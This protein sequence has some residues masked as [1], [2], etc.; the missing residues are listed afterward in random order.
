MS[1][2]GWFEVICL[3]IR[4][5]LIGMEVFLEYAKSRRRRRQRSRR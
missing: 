2:C 4:V 3:S 1:G 5:F